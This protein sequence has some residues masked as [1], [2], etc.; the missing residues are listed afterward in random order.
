M[1]AFATG[2][3]A[4]GLAVGL[5]AFLPMQGALHSA[6]QEAKALRETLET[7]RR[8]TEVLCSPEGRFALL[9]PTPS[10]APD[11]KGR[12]VYDPKSQGVVVILARLRPASDQSAF[13]WTLSGTRARRLGP[14]ALDDAGNA[15]VDYAEAGVSDSLD[16]LAVSLEPAGAST[17][18]LAPAGPVV[19][20]GVLER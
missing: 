8:R 1:G 16:A 6:R 5:L 7:A 2:A 20:M 9:S 19:L 14:L 13:L 10:G 12:A 15:V 17:P 18:P 3:L 11:A 4:A